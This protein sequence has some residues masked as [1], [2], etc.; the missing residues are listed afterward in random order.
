MKNFL[1]KVLIS[2][3]KLP[4][5]ECLH[6]FNQRFAEAINVE[7]FKK[8]EY[9]EVIFYNNK[10]ECIALF[11]DDGTLIEYRQNLSPGHLPEIIKNLAQLKGEIMNIVLTNKG[12]MLEYE[13][14]IRVP[15]FSRFCLNI[16][17]YGE[18][19]AEKKL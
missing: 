2:N 16:S 10:T 9:Y 12:N 5:G 8:E 1:K 18:I 17:E 4:N 6:A 13:I 19:L 14:I 3:K 7:W 11:Q 15:D